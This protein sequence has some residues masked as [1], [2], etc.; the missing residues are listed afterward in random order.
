MTKETELKRKTVGDGNDKGAHLKVS[1]RNCQ[2]G[3]SVLKVL[4]L[5]GMLAGTSTGQ[6][7]EARPHEPMATAYGPAPIS[8]RPS[9][10]GPTG[11]PADAA[12]GGP[13]GATPAAQEEGLRQTASAGTESGTAPEANPDG[14]ARKAASNDCFQLLARW[15]AHLPR[16]DVVRLFAGT[17]E[18]FYRI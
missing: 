6:P 5:L 18:E 9:G 3:P 12:N 16:A 1:S 14:G 4:A 17:A 8:S 13:G 7:M 15:V 2:R 10:A 11:W